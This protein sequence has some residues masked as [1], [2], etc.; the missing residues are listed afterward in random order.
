MKTDLAVGQAGSLLWAARHWQDLLDGL[1]NSL[2]A[3][4][5]VVRAILT[6][7]PVLTTRKISASSMAATVIGE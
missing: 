7:P 1:V 3:S 2:M 5:F 4:Y 6:A